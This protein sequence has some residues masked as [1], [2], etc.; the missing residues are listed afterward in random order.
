MVPPQEMKLPSFS[1]L[2]SLQYYIWGIIERESKKWLHNT[3]DSLK[4]NIVDIK[5]ENHLI[6]AVVSKAT[7]KQSS[8][9]EAVLLNNQ[10]CFSK[11]N[12]FTIFFLNAL[13]I[14][15]EYF[16]SMIICSQLSGAPCMHKIY[17]VFVHAR[18]HLMVKTTSSFSA[19]KI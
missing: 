4:A 16:F 14:S 1:D 12:M 7:L 8:R 13:I 18:I 10:F 19:M 2:N 17:S 15:V 11:L 3:K 6:Q 9:L 5:N